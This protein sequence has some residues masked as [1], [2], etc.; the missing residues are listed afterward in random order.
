[1]KRG[2]GYGKQS[3]SLADKMRTRKAVKFE[4]ETMKVYEY[5]WN[6][7][8]TYHNDV[9]VKYINNKEKKRKTIVFSGLHKAKN[10]NVTNL[11][12]QTEI[13]NHTAEVLFQDYFK[14]N[15]NLENKYF[16]NKELKKENEKML[17]INNYVNFKEVEK[18]NERDFREL[19]NKLFSAIKELKISH[20]VASEVWNN[21]YKDIFDRNEYFDSDIVEIHVEYMKI[22]KNNKEHLPKEEKTAEVKNI[23]S[24]VIEVKENKKEVKKDDTLRFNNSNELHKYIIDNF[25]NKDDLGIGRLKFKLPHSTEYKQINTRIKEDLGKYWIIEKTFGSEFSHVMGEYA[26]KNIVVTYKV[27]YIK[28]KDECKFMN[29]ENI[30]TY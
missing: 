29:I 16:K 11:K 2:W 20:E 21:I 30:T 5:T 26:E 9:T 23:E 27:R 18:L 19:I 15:Q 6:D 13:F 1:M 12:N 10:Y 17:N 24:E 7:Y 3:M 25:K 8:T 22:I 28:T 14:F 4:S